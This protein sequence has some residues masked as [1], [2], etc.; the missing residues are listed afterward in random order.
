[1][2]IYKGL[3]FRH[4][5]CTESES[6]RLRPLCHHSTG[7][8]DSINIPE[9]HPHCCWPTQPQHGKAHQEPLGPSHRH[10]SSNM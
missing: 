7:S 10:D 9:F 6:C 2:I 1:L 8:K 3:V 4:L 5:D